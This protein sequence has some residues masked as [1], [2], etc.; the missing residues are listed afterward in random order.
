MRDQEV[1]IFDL[2]DGK[3][4]IYAFNRI[5]GD[6]VLNEEWFFRKIL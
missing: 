1:Q 2:V 6:E 5:F 3:N 4:N